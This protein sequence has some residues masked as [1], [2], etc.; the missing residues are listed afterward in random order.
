[1]KEFCHFLSLVGLTRDSESEEVGTEEER[2]VVADFLPKK[3]LDWVW[4]E[5]PEIFAKIW[6]SDY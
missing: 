4:G 3:L 5:I 2:T 6:F 1:M